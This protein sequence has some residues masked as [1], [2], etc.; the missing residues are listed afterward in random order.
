MRRTAVAFTTRGSGA[1]KGVRTNE[2]RT[3]SK[4]GDDS[5]DSNDSDDLDE[6]DIGS[7][8]DETLKRVKPTKHNNGLTE[9]DRGGGEPQ[10]NGET[11]PQKHGNQHSWR[12]L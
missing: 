1:E 7:S 8:D 4:A 3:H 6:F 10:P 5:D 11:K 2:K 9:S 12:Y